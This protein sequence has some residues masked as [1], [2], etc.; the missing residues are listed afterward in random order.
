MFFPTLSQISQSINQY[1]WLWVFWREHNNKFSFCQLID[2][3]PWSTSIRSPNIV[4]TVLSYRKEAES[5]L[6]SHFLM[7]AVSWCTEL[8]WINCRKFYSFSVATEP[9]SLIKY[10][11]DMLHDC[12]TSDIHFH[13]HASML[14]PRTKAN[15]ISF[16]SSMIQAWLSHGYQLYHL[17]NSTWPLF[18][19]SGTTQRF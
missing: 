4:R 18:K 14:P 5:C 6:E 19:G 11:D 16:H 10:N 1:R 17:G 8:F 3:A 13:H 9:S 15:D 12:V 7:R 2:F